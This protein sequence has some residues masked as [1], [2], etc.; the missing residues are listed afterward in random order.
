MPGIGETP[1]PIS[2][3]P[4][5]PLTPEEFERTTRIL[6]AYIGPIARVVAKR[7]AA[8]GASRTAF[9]NQVVQSL[10]SEA[11][12]ERFLREAAVTSG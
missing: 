2:S 1:V 5:P 11:Q 10:E 12:R 4:G 3:T 7:A 6:T 9:F 8:N